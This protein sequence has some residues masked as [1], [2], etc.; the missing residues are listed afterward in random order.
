LNKRIVV[1]AS[2]AVLLCIAIIGMMVAQRLRNTTQAIQAI[3]AS[4]TYEASI[5]Q[6]A[7]AQTL[8]AMP[9]ITPS[10]TVTPTIAPYVYIRFLALVTTEP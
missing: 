4:K 7:A 10:P 9:T 8:A 5:S 6:A 1:L 3:E 2:L